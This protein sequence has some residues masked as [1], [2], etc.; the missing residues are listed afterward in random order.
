LTAVEEGFGDVEE[1]FWEAEAG[2]AGG[3]LLG[4]TSGLDGCTS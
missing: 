1:E 4:A 2:A 3:G